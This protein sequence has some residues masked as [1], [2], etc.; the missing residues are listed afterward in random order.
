MV[1]LPNGLLQELN[2]LGFALIEDGHVYKFSRLALGS[3]VY[4]TV[5]PVG[6]AT[7]RV[8][9][10]WRQPASWGRSPNP[11]VPVSLSRLGTSSDGA[12]IELPTR[13]LL[14]RIPRVMQDSVLPMID[15]TTS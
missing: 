13:E 10:N 8:G 12:T 15:L 11:L 1:Q 7:W 5:E 6:P 3:E 2:A 14:E 4:L 9:V